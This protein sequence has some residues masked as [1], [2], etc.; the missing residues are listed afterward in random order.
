AFIAAGVSFIIKRYDYLA[1]LLLSAMLLIF[2]LTLKI[3]MMVNAADEATMQH[4]MFDILKDLCI[5]CGALML[6]NSAKE[7]AA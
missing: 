6:A 1:G 3:P 2:I 4:T 7:R 5:I